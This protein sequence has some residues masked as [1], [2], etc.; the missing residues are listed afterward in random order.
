MKFQSMN[1]K[2]GQSAIEFVIL[3][4]A[5]LFMFVGFLYLIQLR[6]ADS[7]YEAV[8]AAAEEVALTVQDE[9]NLAHNSPNGYSRR[10]TIPSNINGF[11]YQ[12]NILDG[13]VYVR[14]DDGKHAIA[15]PVFNVTGDVIIGTNTIYKINNAVF[16]N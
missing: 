4:M 10:F 7:K 15:L 13:S 1:F 12:A 3:V 9:I 8:S 16:L 5:V 2:K 11:S 14:T 6:I